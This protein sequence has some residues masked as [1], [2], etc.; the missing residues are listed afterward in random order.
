MSVTTE[1]L[2]DGFRQR[3][4]GYF[5]D[6]VGDPALADDLTQE[7]FLAVHGKLDSLHDE[8]RVGGWLFRIASNVLTDHYRSQRPSQPPEERTEE[9]PLLY[10]LNENAEVAGWLKISLERL[11]DSYREAIRLHELEGLKQHEV[12][13]RLGISVS[14]AKS[15]IQRGRRQLKQV[16][17][18]CCQLEQDRRGNVLAYS[19]R[20][21]GKPIER[22]DD[23]DCE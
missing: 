18:D 5:L 8:E 13:T 17:D 12:A 19:R 15:R 7:T 14:G 22:C 20:P 11:P 2:W 6:R 9:P 3:L 23:C 4:R 1:Q 16:I 10:P 21:N